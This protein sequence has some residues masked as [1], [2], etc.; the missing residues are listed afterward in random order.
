MRPCCFVRGVA[1]D[2]QDANRNLSILV[3]PG[4]VKG[5]VMS[6]GVGGQGQVP[7]RRPARKPST[8]SVFIRSLTPSIAHPFTLQRTPGEIR[9]PQLGSMSSMSRSQGSSTGAHAQ[10]LSHFHRLLFGR[11]SRSLFGCNCSSRSRS[12]RRGVLSRARISANYTRSRS[13]YHFFDHAVHGNSINS[14]AGVLR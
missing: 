6:P 8:G 13:S 11:Q 10:E 1:S 2:R 5:K 14:I 3:T 7:G 4:E 12:K 9:R